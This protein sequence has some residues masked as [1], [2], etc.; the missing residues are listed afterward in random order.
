MTSIIK[1]QQTR[2]LTKIISTKIVTQTK[3]TVTI[4]VKALSMDIIITTQKISTV[5]RMHP[6]PQQ[7]QV[8]NAVPP[9]MAEAIAN[10]FKN[11]FKSY[12][13]LER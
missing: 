7:Q 6:R 8:G 4:K 12:V 1:I 11:M 5:H 13:I 10:I 3:Q 9:L 2:I